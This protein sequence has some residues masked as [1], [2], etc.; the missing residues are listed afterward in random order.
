MQK[1]TVI[2]HNYGNK[3][4]RPD[5]YH[6]NNKSSKVNVTKKPEPKKDHNNEVDHYKK[7][8]YYDPKHDNISCNSMCNGKIKE[9][10][11]KYKKLEIPNVRKCPCK[12]CNTY[13]KK[14][15]WY[16]AIKDVVMCL[17]NNIH[18]VENNELNI[19]I[20]QIK[21]HLN[22][23]NICNNVNLINNNITLVNNK[24][25]SV[26]NKI[27]SMNTL[28]LNLIE[29]FNNKINISINDD[30]KLSGVKIYSEIEI[31]NVVEKPLCCTILKQELVTEVYVNIFVKNIEL[32]HTYDCVTINGM[33]S[34]AGK[35][36]NGTISILNTDSNVIYNGIITLGNVNDK[37]CDGQITMILSNRPVLPL[38]LSFSGYIN[39]VIHII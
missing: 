12:T 22:I 13:N 37:R 1:R 39:I 11:D 36:I 9:F 17:M 38:C 34:F 33:T 30:C 25:L 2:V 20:E 31:P 15:E 18:A 32:K 6:N 23:S 4:V 29:E 35:Q 3:S 14:H 21:K 19:D 8:N 26:E 24:Y 10:L 28:V 27:E 7:Y 16:N 5:N